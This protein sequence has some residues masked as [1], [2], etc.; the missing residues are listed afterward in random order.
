M[1]NW[2]SGKTRL[3]EGSF[4]NPFKA[5]WISGW[6]LVRP[7]Y[8]LEEFLSTWKN[9]LLQSQFLDIHQSSCR[10]RVPVEVQEPSFPGCSVGSSDGTSPQ[11]YELFLWSLFYCPLYSSQQRQQSSTVISLHFPFFF[12]FMSFSGW[13]NRG[14]VTASVISWKSWISVIPGL[15][16]LEDDNLLVWFL[17]GTLRC[18]KVEPNTNTQ[19]TPVSAWNTSK[20]HKY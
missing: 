7:V 6:R 10:V 20:Y 4:L 1:L 19:L 18:V 2:Y 13:K 11:S 3:L 5:C 17:W 14:E 12:I 15:T 16:I 9:L 8:C